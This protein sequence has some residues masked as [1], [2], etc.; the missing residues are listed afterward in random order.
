MSGSSHGRRVL[1]RCIVALDAG[2]RISWARGPDGQDDGARYHRD[3]EARFLARIDA[4]APAIEVLFDEL[5]ERRLRV[6][7]TSTPD[8]E[9]QAEQVSHAPQ[10][11]E[12]QLTLWT[13]PA[14][15]DQELRALAAKVAAL[16]AAP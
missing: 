13:E 2:I 16:L 4:A 6:W 14:L 3:E 8:F 15:N 7:P 1:T 5:E 11:E 9:S 12:L 10:I